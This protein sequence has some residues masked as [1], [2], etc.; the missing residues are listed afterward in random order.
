M[1]RPG[2]AG[3]P[4]DR[5]GDLGAERPG[6]RPGAA[7]DS[8]AGR[9]VDP[10]EER[11]GRQTAA[12]RLAELDLEPEPGQRKPTE[13]AR[14]RGRYLWVLGVAVILALI[15]LGSLS[16]RGIG[17]AGAGG[18]GGALRGIPAGQPMPVFAAPLAT[19]GEDGDANVSQRASDSQ[20]A[21]PRPA[22]EVRGPEIVN[23]C[24]LREGPLVLS[25]IVTRGTDCEPQLDS[26]DALAAEFPDVNFAAVVSGEERA[27]V[28]ELVRERGWDFPVA[29]DRDGAVVNIY[30]VGVC[31]TT[32][33]ADPGG[34]VRE[35]KLGTL[36]ARQL[37][38][39]VSALERPPPT[40][41][42]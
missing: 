13:P 29:V 25:F 39:A 41:A 6:D 2:R 8:P 28:E 22:C 20:Q 18:S 17:G 14:P 32:V 27:D 5:F 31:P 9:P 42:G 1:P 11:S 19:G 35:T 38:A 10:R 3:V 12:E 7:D 23:L 33:F 15:V 21:G 40:P 16:I 37:R 4:E 34:K 24:E 26:F 36:D 30:R